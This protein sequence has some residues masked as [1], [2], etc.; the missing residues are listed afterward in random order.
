[1]LRMLKLN[2]D[3]YFSKENTAKAILINNEVYTLEIQKNCNVS[4]AIEIIHYIQNLI[5][6][7]KLEKKKVII[8]TELHMLNAIKQYDLNVLYTEKRK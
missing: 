6:E 1:M 3:Y 5:K 2:N 4:E 7:Q 8:E